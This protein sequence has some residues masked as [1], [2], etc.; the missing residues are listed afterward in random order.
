MRIPY[1]ALGDAVLQ[2]QVAV[3]KLMP[4]VLYSSRLYRFNQRL[5][6]MRATSTLQYG[7][8]LDSR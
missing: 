4:T 5:D 7:T 3:D 8:R 6:V 2:V 1:C